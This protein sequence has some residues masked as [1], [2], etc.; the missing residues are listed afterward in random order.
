MSALQ[1]VKQYAASPAV[2]ASSIFKLAGK[3]TVID[4]GAVSV[5]F[6]MILKVLD[7]NLLADIMVAAVR[8]NG[9]Y[10]KFNLGKKN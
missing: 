4:Q 8:N 9:D 5:A 1:F 7:W 3:A 6:K 2:I 10:K